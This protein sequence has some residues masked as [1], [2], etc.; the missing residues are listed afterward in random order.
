MAFNKNKALGGA[1]TGAAAGAGFGPWGAVIGGVG[2][3]L[4]GGMM[5]GDDGEASRRQQELLMQQTLSEISGI[6]L[7]ELQRIQLE[8]PQW[9]ENL[10]AETLGPSAMQSV[11]VDPRLKSQQMAAMDALNEIQQGGGLNAQDRAN[12]AQIQNESAVADKGRRDAI[13]QNMAQR[14][15]SGSGLELLSQ[16][17]SSQAATD[18]AA[19]Q[20]LNIS[21]MAQ[22]RALDA[23]MQSGQLA[24]QMRGQEFGE[25]SKKAEAED[26]INRFNTQNRQ[27]VNQYNVGGRQD[28]SNQ[29][30]T[31]R[32]QNQ[33]LENQRKQ[34]IFSNQMD[35]A[36]AMG[37]ARGQ[38][39]GRL[40]EN[41]REDIQADANTMA[42]VGKVATS[43]GSYYQNKN[44]NKKKDDQEDGG[45]F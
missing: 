2:G 27:N 5:G 43:L 40:G 14:G 20:G 19:Q 35:K 22:N 31:M 33:M 25:Q 12:L 15:Q 44:A 9:I 23:I 6:P 34:N 10:K 38:E 42:G 28:I 16:L 36:T 29:G 11:Q 7:P 39:V 3:G 41:R 8:N 30:V 13:L 32:N 37:G 18:R 45:W 26:A 4:L 21:G 17:Q 1:A 24:N